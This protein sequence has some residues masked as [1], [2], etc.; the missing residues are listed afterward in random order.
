[1]SGQK[2]KINSIRIKHNSYWIV[3]SSLCF[4]ISFCLGVYPLTSA[5]A[6]Q[7]TN[8]SSEIIKNDVVQESPSINTAQEV[9]GSATYGNNQPSTKSDAQKAEENYR[10]NQEILKAQEAQAAKNFQ[11]DQAIKEAQAAQAAKNSQEDQALASNEESSKAP[12]KVVEGSTSKKI[13]NFLIGNIGL[14]A[15]ALM[16]PMLIKACWKSTSVKIY[17]ASGL[18]YILNEIGLFTGFNRAI[19]K[20]MVAYLNRDDQNKQ[21]DSLETAAK[22]TAEAKKAAKRRALFAKIAAGGF[23]L[24]AAFALYEGYLESKT[25]V[26]TCGPKPEASKQPGGEGKP[27]PYFIQNLEGTSAHVKFQEWLINENNSPI[28]MASILDFAIPYESA[29][30]YQKKNS[31]FDLLTQVLIS[32]AMAAEK[33]GTKNDA[34][35]IT[36]KKTGEKEII[37]NTPGTKLAMTGAGAAA[38]LLIMSKLKMQSTF[39]KKWLK[40]GYA[41]AAGF[42]V[43]AGIAYASS[44]ESTG[45]AE[46]LE[47]RENEYKKLSK[48]LQQASETKV[49]LNAGNVSMATPDFRPVPQEPVRNVTNNA[50]CLGGQGTQIDQTCSCSKTNSCAKPNLAGLS[51]IPSLSGTPLVADSLKSLNGA[52]GDMYAGKLS[53]AKTKGNALANN[54]AKITRLRSGIEKK[55]NSDRLKNNG[56][57]INFDENENAFRNGLK[58]QINDAFNNLTDKEQATVANLAGGYLG[59]PESSI[60]DEIQNIASAGNGLGGAGSAK[61]VNANPKNGTGGDEKENPAFDFNFDDGGLTAGTADGDLALDGTLGSD[62]DSEYV[63]KGDINDD[64]SKNLFKIITTRYLKSAYPVF[65]D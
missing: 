54:A 35:I 63:I 6:Q 49:G 52:A 9:S 43:F 61:D 36:N 41:R 56:K 47:E 31:I 18:L 21:I 17:A 26:P 1:M 24:A 29:K 59:D 45:A 7:V 39:V 28:Q 25:G 65:F 50:V 22:Q 48:S 44:R 15:A 13:G 60:E 64:R 57:P 53:G 16:A 40:N 10:A 27:D 19:H 5:N 8:Q 62:E 11:E 3:K 2:S 42:G 14:F 23:G 55:I 37:V 32:K 4:L 12:V 30:A 46:A 38:G 34:K 20:E 33:V 58:R 51:A